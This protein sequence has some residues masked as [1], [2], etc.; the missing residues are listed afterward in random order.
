VLDSSGGSVN[1]SIALVRRWRNLAALTT[2]G[3]SVQTSTAPDASASIAPEAYC[4]SMCVFLLLSGKTRYVPGGRGSNCRLPF[5]DTSGSFPVPRV[6]FPV[7]PS[8]EMREKRLR[9]TR[10]PRRYCLSN[11][12]SCEFPCK[13]PCLQ[14]IRLETGAISTVSPAN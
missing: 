4:E 13:I 1:D 9:H 14:G 12:E 2:V 8:R 3:T 5:P 6:I 7:N 11:P 10:F